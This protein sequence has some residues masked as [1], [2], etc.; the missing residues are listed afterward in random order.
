MQRR[1]RWTGHVIRMSSNRLPCKVLYGEFSQDE[2]LKGGQKKRFYDHLKCTVMK[3]QCLEYIACRN[4]L[5]GQL[6]N[7]AV[8]RNEWRSTFM[9]N[10]DQVS[11]NRRMRRHTASSSLQS[12]MVSAATFATKCANQ[13]LVS[14][15]IFEVT[16]TDFIAQVFDVRTNEMNASI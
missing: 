13:N 11:G 14:R 12:Q 7:L 3:Y 8:D 5:P 16:G 4:T 2:C 15:A 10:F 6:E 1:L 9:T